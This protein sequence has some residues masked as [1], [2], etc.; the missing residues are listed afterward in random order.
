MHFYAFFFE[1]PLVVKF[2]IESNYASNFLFGKAAGLQIS[3]LYMILMV[4]LLIVTSVFLNFRQLKIYVFDKVFA[5][6]IGLNTKRIQFLIN[7]LII[8]AISIGIQSVGVVLMA[9]LL[10][11]PAAAA[12]F[13]TN[14]LET[15]IIVSA[16]FG[17]IG[18]YVGTFVSY[19]FTNSPT[20]PWIVV[21]LSTIAF[22]SFIIAP[23]KG[24]LYKHIE[25]KR[26]SNLILTQA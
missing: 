10:I 9:A 20:G 12:R 26:N 8:L 18:S 14:K 6:S 21:T 1:N 11:T 22:T 3:D 13:W 4:F 2:V 24:L 19:Y 16:I 25:K 15:M 23:K 7:S 5:N 17:M